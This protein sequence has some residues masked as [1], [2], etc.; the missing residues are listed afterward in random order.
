MTSYATTL[1]AADRLSLEE[2]EELAATLR[3]RIAEKRR[4][5]LLA[6]VKDARAENARGACKPAGVASIM[7]QVRR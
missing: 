5:E 6:A 7:R 2:Q 3:R 4:A 1:E